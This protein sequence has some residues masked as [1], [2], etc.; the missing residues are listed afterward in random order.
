MIVIV[1]KKIPKII[2][3]LSFFLCLTLLIFS[4]IS[5][6]FLPQTLYVENQQNISLSAPLPMVAKMEQNRATLNLFGCIPIS[7]ANVQFSNPPTLVVGGTAFGI[8][9]T[10][11]SGRR[12]RPE[13]T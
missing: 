4:V 8:T 2:A 6:N 3:I 7:T 10:R 11:T 1:L 5:A 9:G 12:E 13:R